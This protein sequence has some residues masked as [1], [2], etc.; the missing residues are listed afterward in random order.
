M[1][2]GIFFFWPMLFALE[3]HPAVAAYDV[4]IPWDRF[5]LHDE[6]PSQGEDY[7]T[8]PVTSTSVQKC[9]SELGWESAARLK[10][11]CAPEKFSSI[12]S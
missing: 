12:S 8:S 7:K 5:V 3:S 9:V 6:L 2:V 10:G 1:A 11:C 4:G